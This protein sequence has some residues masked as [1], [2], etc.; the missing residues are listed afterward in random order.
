MNGRTSTASATLEDYGMLAQGLLDLAL[1]G[2]ES[3]YAVAG[4]TLIDSTMAESAD[5]GRPGSV[6]FAVPF[7]VPGG[8]D[9]VLLAHG[10]ALAADPSEGAYPSGLTATSRAA[11]TLYL[12]TGERRYLQAALATM[13]LVAGQAVPRPIG[14]GAALALMADLAAEPVQLVVVSPA[15]A[16]RESGVFTA[17]RTHDAALVAAVTEPQASTFSVAGFELFDGRIAQDE[18]PTAYLCREFV[19]RLPT[20][21]ARE[22]V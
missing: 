6:P 18:Q 14:F 8:V 12:L 21:D 10:T 16:Q 20:T 5:P 11:N 3:E 2:G 22:L 13:A 9:P 1:A 4:R 17:A 19:C 15:G 7:A